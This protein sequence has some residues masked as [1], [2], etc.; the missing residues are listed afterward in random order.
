[1]DD[2]DR[3]DKHVSIGDTNVDDG[4]GILK[5]GSDTND[6]TC[7]S[8]TC[9]AISSARRP[10]R[11]SASSMGPSKSNGSRTNREAIC[12]SSRRMNDGLS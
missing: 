12:A 3:H 6:G 9:E 7:A 8:N 10:G 1:M 2:L 4:A 11:F 5:C